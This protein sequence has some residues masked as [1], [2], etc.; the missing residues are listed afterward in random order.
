[1]KKAQSYF[2][3]AILFVRVRLA[4]CEGDRE[5]RPAAH[6]LVSGSFADVKIRRNE[7][8]HVSITWRAMQVQT[9]AE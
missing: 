5:I 3:R 9:V 4:G 1:M 8:M 6:Y 2:D 7:R